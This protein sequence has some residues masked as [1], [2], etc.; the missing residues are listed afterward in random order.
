MAFGQS[1][2]YFICRMKPLSFD[3]TPCVD[4]VVKCQWL[5]VRELQLSPMATLLTNRIA[6]LVLTGLK[7][8]FEQFDINYEQW[9]SL[10]SGQTYNL[11]MTRNR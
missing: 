8:G 5:P 4:E 3:I 9:P 2:L 10:L 6:E 1:D 11:F 7:D